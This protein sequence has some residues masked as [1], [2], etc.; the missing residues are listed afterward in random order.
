MRL[1][2]SGES[3]RL[4][5]PPERLQAQPGMTIEESYWLD[6]EERPV[7]TGRDWLKG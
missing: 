7:P 4:L 6:E 1:I 3:F 5:C 2:L